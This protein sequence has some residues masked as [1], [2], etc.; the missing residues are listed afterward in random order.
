MREEAENWLTQAERDLKTAR[1]LLESRHY[2]AS[3][4]FLHQACEK[5][6]KAHHLEVGKRRIHTHNL[7]RLSAKLDLGKE[8]LGELRELSPE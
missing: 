8:L 5:A 6:L 3:V 4:F 7:V 2:Y 1:H